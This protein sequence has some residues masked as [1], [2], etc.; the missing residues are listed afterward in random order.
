MSDVTMEGRVLAGKYELTRLLGQGGMGAVYE[1]RNHLGKRYAVKLLLKPEFAQDAGLT[2]RFFK[3]AKASA[4]IESEHIVQ[5]YDTGVDPDTS[6]PF[7]IMELLKGEDLEHTIARV[8]AI[9]VL[10]SARVIS[11]ASMGLGRA[12][13]AGIV[14]R[15]IKP[16][17][18]FMTAK[19][20]G[21]SVVKILDFGIAKQTMDALSSNEGAGLTKT[22]SMLGTPLYM[23]PE[24]AQG[25]KS[26][27]GRTDIWSLG[28]CLY[29]AL[30]GR[31]P[32]GDVDTLGALILSI[33]SRDVMPLQDIA[34]WVPPELAQVVHRCLQRDVSQ[35]MPSALALVQA[36]GPFTQGSLT[37][38]PDVLLGVEEA[39]R[40]A[41]QPRAEIVQSAISNA[42]FTSSQPSVA[43]TA[44]V[45]KPASKAPMVFGALAL[46]GVLVGGGIFA[47]TKLGNGGAKPADGKA[48]AAQ[49]KETATAAAPTTPP[50][51]P[52]EPKTVYLPVKVPKGSKVKVGKDDV[53]EKANKDGKIA[54][55]GLDG[56]AFI[57][58]IQSGK[59]QPLVQKVYIQD[60]ATIPEEIDFS[61]G[62]QVVQAPKPKATA[63]GP[64]PTGAAPKPP[65]PGT[66][67]PTAP[68]PTADKPKPPPTPTVDK[69]KPNIS[70]TFD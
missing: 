31:T 35:R 46:V 13:E 33:C 11:Q 9:N 51:P 65:T 10:G 20:N 52:E 49:P 18:I 24:Q 15:D 38:I 59:E 36:L 17:N 12:H 56:A 61:K 23:S 53:S 22:G 41:I 57:V 45:A 47:A 69:P 2:A 55:T 39:Q 1:A 6:F 26:L 37:I 27:D 4:A 50:P 14:H 58:T 30:S 28:M 40:L 43:T 7:I 64:A 66:T 21:D 29:E 67:E 42:N 8:G 16:A 3:E 19:E 44:A 34:P 25:L 32:W 63:A 60:G 5:V 68:A 70:N 54:L 62:E 48:Q